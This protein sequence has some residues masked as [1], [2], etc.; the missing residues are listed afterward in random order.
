M[1]KKKIYASYCAVL[2]K[3]DVSAAFS[4][5]KQYCLSN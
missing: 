3:Q 2:K 1:K 5:N 4:G